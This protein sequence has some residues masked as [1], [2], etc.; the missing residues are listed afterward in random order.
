MERLGES[1]HRLNLWDKETR[2]EAG[3][4]RFEL[5]GHSSH[6]APEFSVLIEGGGKAEVSKN[7]MPP[8]NHLPRSGVRAVI[9]N[10]L[11][12]K[13]VTAFQNL[14]AFSLFMLVLPFL[15]GWSY[16]VTKSRLQQSS[17]LLWRLLFFY[18]RPSARRLKKLHFTTAP[19]VYL[20][21]ILLQDYTIK[22]F[23]QI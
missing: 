16:S 1:T 19:L 11:I 21:D 2:E 14:L 7:K 5:L 3:S 9:G 23:L 22:W 20:T 10:A 18:Q 17:C 6:T 8:L 12:I 13:K 15:H 4:N